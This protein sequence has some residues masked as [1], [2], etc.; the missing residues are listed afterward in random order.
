M[1]TNAFGVEV[2]FGDCDPAGI[3][4][5]PN[6]FRWSDAAFAKLIASAGLDPECGRRFPL[7]EVGSKFRGPTSVGDMLR[8]VSTVREIGRK[9]I[10]V[11]HDF[12]LGD[13]LIVEGWEVRVWRNALD[14]DPKKMKAEAIPEPIVKALEGAG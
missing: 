6:Y 12:F 11:S 7:V 2:H 1:L 4:F 14:N 9:T 8:V 13:D 5:F 3:V 10:K